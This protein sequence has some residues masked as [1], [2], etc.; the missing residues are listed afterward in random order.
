MTFLF[1]ACVSGL[2]SVKIKCNS[3]CLAFLPGLE[4][5]SHDRQ[6]G[7]FESHLFLEQ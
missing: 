3:T 6:S 2:Q 1:Q 7:F 5:G 4:E